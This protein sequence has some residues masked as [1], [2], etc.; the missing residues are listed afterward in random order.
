M[1][2][3]VVLCGPDDVVPCHRDCKHLGG[4]Q[5]VQGAG[6]RAHSNDSSDRAFGDGRGFGKRVPADVQQ[7]IWQPNSRQRRSTLER[8]VS[9]VGER[10]GERHRRQRRALRE[11]AVANVGERVGEYHRH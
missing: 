3:S 7:R 1:N 11:R 2:R 8:F 4:A 5:H 10:V 9:K 6:L